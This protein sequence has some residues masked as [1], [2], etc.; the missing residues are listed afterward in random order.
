LAAGIWLIYLTEL[1]KRIVVRNP[2][3]VF[4]AGDFCFSVQ[5]QSWMKADGRLFFLLDLLSA[6]I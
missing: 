6:L 2:L 5:I 1:F 4:E 3:L